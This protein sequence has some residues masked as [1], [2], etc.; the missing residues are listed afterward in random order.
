MDRPALISLFSGAGGLDLGLEMAGFDTR[1]LIDAEP[2]ACETLR[3][4]KI[5]GR[6]SPSEKRKLLADAL[7]QHCYHDAS[8]EDRNA[9]SSRILSVR[10]RELLL[11]ATV[12][13]RDIREVTSAELLDA[14]GLRK[15]QELACI[16]GGPP[17]QPFSR[18][19]KRKAVDDESHGDL[20]FEFVRIVRDLRPRW[21]VF[22]NVKG[23]LLTKTDVVTYSCPKCRSRDLLSFTDRMRWSRE[24]LDPI[25]CPKCRSLK[26]DLRAASVPGGSLEIILREFERI[27]YLCYHGVLNAADF[28]APQMRERLFIVGS[29]DK[30]SFSWPTITHS[31]PKLAE[32]NHQSTPL[33]FPAGRRALQLPPW[34]TTLDALWRDGHPRFGK[35]D[36]TH[37]VLWV[38]NVVRPHAE[39]VTWSLERPSP[40]IGAHQ[41][42]K[43]AIAPY[44]VP[45]AQ[46]RRQQ[47]HVKG[48]RQGD[49]RPVRV[50]HE[51]LSDLELLTLQTFPPSWYL[52]GTRMQR[53]FQIGNAVPP[54]LARAVGN[55]LL[56]SHQEA[57]AAT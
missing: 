6:A 18:A 32:A 37:A 26:T 3:R 16:A 36:P 31:S 8:P 43:L 4:N 48:K 47:W 30:E 28:G 49:T 29:R 53:A 38:K 52:H 56:R 54:C 35:L 15:N 9:L 50:D 27:G 44:G 42:A 24:E 13:E 20:F 39:P 5:L 11:N 34:R 55:A 14:C 7:E 23:L 41:A 17:C 22:E 57:V 10:A 2:H 46:L 33:L 19:G 1:V 51:Y 40:T 12:L 21:F 45:E 25:S